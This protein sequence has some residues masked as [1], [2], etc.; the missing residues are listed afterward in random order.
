[1]PKGIP[2]L[3]IHGFYEANQSLIFG[4]RLGKKEYE[5]KMRSRAEDGD[6]YVDQQREIIYDF[7]NSQKKVIQMNALEEFL[8]NCS[9]I[10]QIVVLGHSMG[11]VDSEYM[12]QIERILHPIEW[13]IS[14]HDSDDVK[15]N[16]QRYSFVSK[17]HFFNW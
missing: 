4:Y 6:Y 2:L 5:R 3:H 7:Y 8:H 1:M 17:I 16:S 9:E 13:E 15:V 12:E 10:N 11:Q 14:V